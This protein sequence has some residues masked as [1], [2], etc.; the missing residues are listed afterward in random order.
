ML[1]LARLADIGLSIAEKLERQAELAAVYSETDA[2]PRQPA[3][4]QAPGRDRPRLRPGLPRRQ[5]CDRA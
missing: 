5:P 1:R 4:F 3:P 2:V